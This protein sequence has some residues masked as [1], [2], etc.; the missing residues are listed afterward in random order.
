VLISHS[1]IV[2][3][4]AGMLSWN[5]HAAA[6]LQPIY[7][8]NAH[9]AAAVGPDDQVLAYLPMSHIFEF[10][11]EN[12]VALI[13]GAG[14]GYGTPQTLTDASP[15]VA[16]GSRGDAPALHPTFLTAV[17]AV[18]ERVRA[19]VDGGLRALRGARGAVARPAFSLA[20]AISDAALRHCGVYGAGAIV[21]A[22]PAARSRVCALVARAA[23]SLCG[24][25]FAAP[26]AALAVTRASRCRRRRGEVPDL[27][28][29][30]PGHGP[31]AQGRLPGH[32]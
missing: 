2:A 28:G 27:Q 24:A 21:T 4:I 14:L 11:M 25:V 32:Q 31:C 19:S 15:G 6:T 17:P 9:V 8:A 3:A 18:L 23:T 12:T 29:P 10:V 30:E 22:G 26:R 20:F 16:P 13:A 5:T 7:G 1:A